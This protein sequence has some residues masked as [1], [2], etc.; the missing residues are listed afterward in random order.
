MASIGKWR[1]VIGADIGQ[2]KDPSAVVRIERDNNGVWWVRDAD[3]LQLGIPYKEVAAEISRRATAHDAVVVIDGTG[4]GRVV[5]EL[6]RDGGCTHAAITITGGLGERGMAVSKVSLVTG[7]RA[8]MERGGLRVPAVH[9]DLVNELRSFRVKVRG[10]S[11]EAYEAAPG[12]HDDLVM[13]L[14]LAVWGTALAEVVR[15][16]EDIESPM[17]AYFRTMDE[18]RRGDL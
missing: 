16:V 13:A 1:S 17:E 5:S 6:L 11:T 12:E 18:V 4:V 9:T 2:A 14:A 8:L 15:D 10:T 7:L 3:R